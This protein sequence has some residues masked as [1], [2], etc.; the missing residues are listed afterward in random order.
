M[1]ANLDQCY[2]TFLSVIIFVLTYSVCWIRVEKLAREKLS[3][4]V[5]KLINY[6]QKM[7]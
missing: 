6:G 4:L 1:Y 7:F 2:K 3:S 5:Q